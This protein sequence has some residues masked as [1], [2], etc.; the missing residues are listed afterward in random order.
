MRLLQALG[1]RSL[2]LSEQK[3]DPDSNGGFELGTWTCMQY[4]YWFKK[5]CGDSLPQNMGKD[6]IVEFSKE[7]S[8][9]LAQAV[10]PFMLE[11]DLTD[12][13]S[14]EERKILES[15]HGAG[16]FPVYPI[17]NPLDLRNGKWYKRL[18]D[19]F[20]SGEAVWYSM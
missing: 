9:K 10:S 4:H 1:T 6:S 7:A 16:E 18:F 3:N 17:C 19:I 8:E 14:P 2:A 12:S 20:N 13:C 15:W 11:G 5:I